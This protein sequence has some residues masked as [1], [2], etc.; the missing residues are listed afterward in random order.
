MQTPMPEARWRPMR[1]ADLP[2]VEAIAA[3]V[4]PDFYERPEVFAER[5]ALYPLGVYVLEVDGKPCGYVFSHPYRLGTLPAL[6]SLLGDLPANADCYYLHDLAL[7]PAARGVG[8]GGT[9]TRL[10]VEQARASGFATLAL[11][12]V[13]GSV[14]FWTRHGFREVDHPALRTKLSSYEAQARYMQRPL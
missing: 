14:P 9:A 7:L 11:V 1:T 13:N 5:I 3:E 10:L 6:D 4:H 2:A 8:A 12:A